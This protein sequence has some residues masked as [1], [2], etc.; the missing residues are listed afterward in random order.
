MA[1]RITNWR[2]LEIYTASDHQYITFDIM[3]NSKQAKPIS[4]PRYNV[5]KINV[6]KFI[7]TIKSS[8]GEVQREDCPMN[9][10]G[11]TMEIVLFSGCRILKIQHPENKTI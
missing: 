4:M 2:V 5:E 8:E 7:N 10:V 6:E 3:P 1:G 9:I 11:K